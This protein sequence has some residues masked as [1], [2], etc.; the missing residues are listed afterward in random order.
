M[1][2]CHKC[3]ACSPAKYLKCVHCHADLYVV[4]FVVVG[5]VVAIIWGK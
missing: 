2:Y 1:K 4:G 5:F 3:G